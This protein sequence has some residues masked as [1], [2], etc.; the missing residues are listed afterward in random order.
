MGSEA[1]TS[2]QV[3]IPDSI[4]NA[5]MNPRVETAVGDQRYVA[6]DAAIALDS[7]H[8]GQQV[9]GSGYLNSL[10]INF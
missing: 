8:N 7:A 6:D 9:S 3:T 1:H 5:G 2:V 4:L 10:R